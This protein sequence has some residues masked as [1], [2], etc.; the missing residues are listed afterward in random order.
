MYRTHIKRHVDIYVA[1]QDIDFFLCRKDI[2]NIYNRL[3]KGNYQLH[4]NDEM[5]VK[6]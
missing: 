4:K 5:S 2:V 6:L 3:A 1:A